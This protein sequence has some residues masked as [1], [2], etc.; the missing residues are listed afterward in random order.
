M[1]RTFCQAAHDD[2][3]F[4]EAGTAWAVYAAL[5][6]A[7]QCGCD[8]VLLPFVAGGLYAGP[9]RT[10]PGLLEAYVRNIDRMLVEG[11]MPD[12]TA[13]PPLGGVFRNVCVVVLDRLPPAG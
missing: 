5:A 4:L 9:W 11:T 2:R 3:Q 13:V 8:V 7:A 1:R 10:A 6:A 12:G